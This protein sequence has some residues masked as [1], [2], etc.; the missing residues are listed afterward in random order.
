LRIGSAKNSS[1]FRYCI[2]CE[3]ESRP[4]QACDRKFF[5][6]LKTIVG[7]IPVI[8]VFT[9]FDKVIRAFYE[10]MRDDGLNPT[11]EEIRESALAKYKKTWESKWEEI[12]P[13]GFGAKKVLMANPGTEKSRIRREGRFRLSHWCDC[14]PV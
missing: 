2:S 9:K 6:N 7:E 10:D 8:V 11:V 12:I 13:E 3:N 4:V 5:G 1:I 14:R